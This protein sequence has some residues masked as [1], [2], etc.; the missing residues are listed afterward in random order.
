M[1]KILQNH[2]ASLLETIKSLKKFIQISLSFKEFIVKF[3]IEK[4]KSHKII[5]K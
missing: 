3:I 2:I 4:I 1:N 5:H